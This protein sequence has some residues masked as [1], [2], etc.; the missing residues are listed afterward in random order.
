MVGPAK[1]GHYLRHDRRTLPATQLPRNRHRELSA[2]V[3]DDVVVDAEVERTARRREDGR[4]IT[5]AERLPAV[6]AADERAR[7]HLRHRRVG[8][9]SL[10]QRALRNCDVLRIV[11]RSDIVR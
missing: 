8:R 2:V 9:V 7:Q 3:A 4:E 11:G 6:D 10:Q 1:A 5:D